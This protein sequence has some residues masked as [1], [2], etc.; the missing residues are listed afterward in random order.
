M[1][2]RTKTRRD[3]VRDAV[4]DAR[5]SVQPAAEAAL[6]KIG[7]A[8]EQIVTTVAATVVPALEDAKDK[9]KDVTKDSVKPAVEDAKDKALETYKETLVPL[10][11][12]ALVEGKARGRR[13]AVKL[14]VADE[15][16]K[17]HKLRNLL[18]ILGLAGL[19]AFVYKKLTGK[20]ADP[21]WTQS[22]DSSATRALPRGISLAWRSISLA[23]AI[24]CR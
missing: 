2:L 14:G 5:S 10:A 11:A 23:V 17:T 24:F 13:A 6:D 9:A 15:P 3:K 22:R 16:K 4:E 19:A 20:D 7:E 8:T 1:A 18:V 21:A 12:A